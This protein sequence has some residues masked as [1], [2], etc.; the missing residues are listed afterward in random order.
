MRNLLPDLS[1]VQGV[2]E[3]VTSSQGLTL[4]FHKAPAYA[5]LD[6]GRVLHGRV[7]AEVVGPAGAIVDVGWDERLWHNRPLPFPGSLHPE[8][9]QVDSWRLDGSQR[10]LST[11]D[12]RAGRFLWI[13]VW[14]AGQPVTL[15][16]LRV[17]EEH[18]PVSYRGSFSSN[19]P[20]LDRIWQVGVDSLIPNMTDAYTDTPWRERGLWLGDAYVMFKI[21]QVSFGDIA[22]FRRSLKLMG[23]GIDV[24]GKPAA[25]VPGGSSVMILD[26]GMLWVQGLREYYQVSGDLDLLRTYY[27]ALRRLMSYIGSYR[28]HSTGLL[29]I[30]VRHWSQSA[31]I[32]WSNP[33]ARYGQSVAL[34]SMYYKTLQDAAFI[35]HV[36]DHVPDALSY[37]QTAEHLLQSM[38]S[39]LFQPSLGLYAETILGGQVMPPSLHAQAWSISHHAVLP[40]HR[41]QMVNGLTSLISLESQD[42]LSVPSLR[43]V[44]PYG[45]YWLLKA[46]GES[47]QIAEGIK[48]I[49]A[50][51]G[52]LIQRGATNWWEVFFADQRPT[53][54]L[55]HGWGGSPTWFLSTYVLGGRQIDHERWLFQPALL[56]NFEVAGSLPLGET[57]ILHLSWKREGCQRGQAEVESPQGYVGTV[58][59]P[60]S[61]SEVFFGDKV[62]WSQGRALDSRVS[63]RDDYLLIQPVP[64][65]V[66]RLELRWDCGQLYF[67]LVLQNTHAER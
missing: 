41:K 61:V 62:V 26:F 52:D 43:G 32:D 58:K 3:V 2:P 63:V 23:D 33:Y 25:F 56:P 13:S 55:S 10:R 30:P 39:L 5:I 60:L 19:E 14:N 40:Q 21:N 35:A 53:A 36:T 27:P 47:G 8:M 46:L 18:Y 45:M 11:I 66:H 9:N 28:S 29:D 1:P 57:G 65:G 67:P 17:L 4:T 38:A 54:S 64:S 12:A 44:Q 20:M 59:L 48:V 37:S 34:N 51:Y 24:N 49:K 22:L 31:L 42:R 15:K 50:Y 6:L 7:V 16:N